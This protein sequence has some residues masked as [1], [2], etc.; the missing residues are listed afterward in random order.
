M[1]NSGLKPY[2]CETSKYTDQCIGVLDIKNQE[3]KIS[4]SKISNHIDGQRFIASGTQ[5]LMNN[6]NKISEDELKTLPYF[7]SYQK[8]IPSKVSVDIVY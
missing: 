4:P 8:G 1:A 5:I 7:Q 3:T 6:Y 2:T